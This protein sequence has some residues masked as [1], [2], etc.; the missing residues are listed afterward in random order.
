VTLR[1]SGEDVSRFLAAGLFR[2][3]VGL[4]GTGKR[5]SPVALRYF[6]RGQGVIIGTSASRAV[7]QRGQLEAVFRRW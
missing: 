4:C 2:E 1:Q 5:G 7:T 3:G 6:Y